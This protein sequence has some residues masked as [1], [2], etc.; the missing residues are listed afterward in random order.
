MPQDFEGRYENRH[1]PHYKFW[2]IY[3][4]GDGFLA[5][6]GRIGTYGQEKL[7]TFGEARKKAEEKTKKGY[8]KVSGQKNE[9]IETTTYVSRLSKVQ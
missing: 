7:Y 3:D 2:E 9:K 1:K 5:T 8:K 4:T 6:W